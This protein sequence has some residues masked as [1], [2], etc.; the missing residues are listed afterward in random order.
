MF[1]EIVIFKL[2]INKRILLKYVLSVVLDFTQITDNSNYFVFNFLVVY[3]LNVYA[4]VY[5]Y[6]NTKALTR[7]VPMLCSDAGLVN[8]FIHKTTYL[9]VVFQM[10]ILH[11]CR[12]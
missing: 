8:I 11:D 7:V 6:Y 4:N 5:F 2:K 9:C 1:R 3:L 10:Y 12:F